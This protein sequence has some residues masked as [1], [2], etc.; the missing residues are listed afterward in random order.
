MPTNASV[1]SKSASTHRATKAP[2]CWL[3]LESPDPLDA[4]AAEPLPGAAS[5]PPLCPDT[6]K[7]AAPRRSV[8]R[9]PR[10]CT[11]GY[12]YY[13]VDRNGMRV[14]RQVP[15]LRLHGLWL[16]GIGFAVG[17]KVRIT[18]ANGALLITAEPAA[19]PAAKTRRGATAA[20]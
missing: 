6:G 5:A 12:R 3:K 10:Q 9:R 17:G 19:P 7:V 14:G 11:I 1:R 4:I 16:E 13:D 8:P 20:L 15:S 18:M 2:A